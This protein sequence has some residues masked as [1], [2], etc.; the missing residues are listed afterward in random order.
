M[1]LKTVNEES[2]VAIGDTIR[3]KTG[4]E[5]ALEFPNGMINAIAGM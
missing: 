5:D 3:A 1:A 2:L 4:T